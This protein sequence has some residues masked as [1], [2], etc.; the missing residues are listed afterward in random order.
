MS[1]TATRPFSRVLLLQVCLRPPRPDT[2]PPDG[3]MGVAKT[4]FPVADKTTVAAIDMETTPRVVTAAGRL[5]GR[6]AVVPP[7]MEATDHVVAM[8]TTMAKRVTTR[9]VLVAMPQ[10]TPMV[11]DTGDQPVTAVTPS[12]PPLSP[13][14]PVGRMLL[15]RPPAF[16]ARPR[17]PFGP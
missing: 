9:P 10:T 5:L 4:P 15:P 14:G 13:S 17:R 1:Q 12:P 16:A 11:A 7:D 3:H 2:R 6:V 8:P